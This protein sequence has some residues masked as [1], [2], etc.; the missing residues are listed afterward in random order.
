VYFL[1]HVSDALAVLDNVCP[2]DVI[3]DLRRFFSNSDF[4]TTNVRR[5]FSIDNEK[6][7]LRGKSS[8]FNC[9]DLIDATSVIGKFAIL[10]SELTCDFSTIIGIPKVNWKS[11][12]VTPWIYSTGSGFIPHVDGDTGYSGGFVFWCHEEWDVTW[13]GHLVVFERSVE[14]FSGPDSMSNPPHLLKQSVFS[15][16]KSLREPGIGTLV[17]PKRNRLVLLSPKVPHMVTTIE[18]QQAERLSLVGFFN[19]SFTSSKMR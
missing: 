6:P 4:E 10:L 1:V 9:G 8:M 11:F 7:P 16:E 13:G 15:K 19:K 17:L 5:E 18:K 2:D 12:S 14:N 3:E